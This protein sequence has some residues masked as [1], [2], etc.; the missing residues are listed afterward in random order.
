[1]SRDPSLRVK[2]VART[3][4]ERLRA[5]VD[6]LRQEGLRTDLLRPAGNPHAVRVV[7]CAP[8]QSAYEYD[9]D[10]GRRVGVL[11]ESIWSGRPGEPGC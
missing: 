6:R 11:T 4:Y 2:A 10:D 8:E 7:A 9:G 3:P 5:H 1:M